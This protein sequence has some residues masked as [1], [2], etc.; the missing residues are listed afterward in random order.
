MFKINYQ[1]LNLLKFTIIPNL[2]F[3]YIFF[4]F[5]FKHAIDYVRLFVSMIISIKFSVISSISSNL[6]VISPLYSNF[7]LISLLQI[8]WRTTKYQF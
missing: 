3:T 2:F 1:L 6:R 8:Y 4:D 7:A 5:D